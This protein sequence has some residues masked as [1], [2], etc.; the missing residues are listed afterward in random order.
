ML[1]GIERFS[2]IIESAMG[3]PVSR[4]SIDLLGNEALMVGEDAKIELSN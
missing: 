3:K 1:D 4:E 2:S